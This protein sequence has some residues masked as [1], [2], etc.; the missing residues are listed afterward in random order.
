[1]FV[2]SPVISCTLVHI[3]VFDRGSGCR[4][5]ID[6]NSARFKVQLYFI[7]PHK[8]GSN[9][10]VCKHRGHTCGCTL[11]RTRLD[12]GDVARDSVLDTMNSRATAWMHECMLPWCGRTWLQLCKRYESYTTQHFVSW[13]SEKRLKVHADSISRRTQG[14]LLRS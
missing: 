6:D 10:H 13:I 11:L 5:T 1:M 4:Y 7:V 14:K 3:L 12:S 8:W 9:D 2:S